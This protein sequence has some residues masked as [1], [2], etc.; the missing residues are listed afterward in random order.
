MDATGK[1]RF[2]FAATKTERIIYL[3]LNKLATPKLTFVNSPLTAA[4]RA[5]VRLASESS[6]AAIYCFAPL[7]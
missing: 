3:M 5:Q 6:R 4:R 1:R 7:A 2:N